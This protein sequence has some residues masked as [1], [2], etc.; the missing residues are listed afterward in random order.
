MTTVSFSVEVD[1]PPER[2]WEVI[3]NPRNLPSWDRHIVRVTGVPRAGLGPG[4]S[5]VTEM[6]VL[7]V[8]GRVRATVI[9][10]D[11]PRRARVRLS[12]LVDATVTTT[13]RP[14]DG[15]RSR[16]EHVVDYRFP[17]GPLGD[18]AAR[19]LRLVGGARYALRRGTIAQKREIESTT[20]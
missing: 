19:S 10:W 8:H 20:A 5:Y 14:L 1:A 6:R 2:V 17:G 9:E 4:A 11:P 3:A 13:V 16:L 7:R 12:G 18:V 15:G